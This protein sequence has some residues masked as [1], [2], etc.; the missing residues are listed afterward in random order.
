M[1]GRKTVEEKEG[2]ATV[3]RTICYAYLISLRK[4]ESR[5]FNLIA[6]SKPEKRPGEPLFDLLDLLERRAFTIMESESTE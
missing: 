1:T 5:P 3:K 2:Y 6:K 4:T